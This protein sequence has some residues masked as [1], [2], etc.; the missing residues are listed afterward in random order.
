[1]S[2]KTDFLDGSTGLNTKMNDAFTEGGAFVT[3][4]ASTLSTALKSN[5]AQ[6]L[7]AFTVNVLYSGTLNTTYLRSNNG[8]NLLLK[9]FLAG[10]VDGMAAQQVYSYEC[11]PALNVSQSSVT[12]VDFNFSF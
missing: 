8:N 3:A 4:S 10:I 1:M 2:L 9:S 7:T 5:A 6:G 11:T 12:S